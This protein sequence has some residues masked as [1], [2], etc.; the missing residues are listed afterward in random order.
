MSGQYRAPA[1][2]PRYPTLLSTHT[3]P[4]GHTPPKATTTSFR[5]VQCASS[6][7][8][9]RHCCALALSSTFVGCECSASH[10]YPLAAQTFS[11]VC[12]SEST[13]YW[14]SSVGSDAGVAVACIFIREREQ[15][16]QQQAAS[17]PASAAVFVIVFV[18][19]L[20][21]CSALLCV[22]AHISPYQHF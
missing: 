6:V 11:C 12:V 15:Q 2:P 5:S 17:A 20:V 10:A 19:V 8:C 3:T 22:R 21:L 9:L 7:Q 16:Q 1:T 14:P 4:F 18:F 13:R